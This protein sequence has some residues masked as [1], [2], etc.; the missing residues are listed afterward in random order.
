VV[1]NPYIAHAEWENWADERRIE[2]IHLPDKA[3]VRIYTLSGDLVVILDH[4]NGSG[5]AAWDIQSVN[6]QAVAPGIYY[7]HVD[8]PYGEKIGKFAII[9]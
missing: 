8:S 3:T 2:F 1:P 4:D 7:Y 6:D 5:T 9:K